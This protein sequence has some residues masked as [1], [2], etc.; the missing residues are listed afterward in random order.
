MHLDFKE[1]Y[2]SL[3][4]KEVYKLCKCIWISK[5]ITNFVNAFRFQR[6]IRKFGF[7]RRLRKFVNAFGFQRRLRK[8]VNV[9]IL[10]LKFRVFILIMT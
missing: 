4:F 10:F 7:Q 8:F 2:E 5:K 6:R 3:Y 9:F 1:E